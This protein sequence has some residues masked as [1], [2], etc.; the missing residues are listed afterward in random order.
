M[1]TVKIGATDAL[2]VVIQEGLAAG[3][4]VVVDGVDKLQDG[5]KVST[6]G[7]SQVELVSS[8]HSAS[9]AGASSRRTRDNK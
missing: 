9:S 5:S 3:D 2:R 7:S 4:T 1:R 6:P 8:E